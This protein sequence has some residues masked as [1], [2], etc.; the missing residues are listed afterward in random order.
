M[1]SLFLGFVLV[2]V[3]SALWAG[4]TIQHYRNIAQHTQISIPRCPEDE[5]LV[6]AGSFTNGRWTWYSCG[7]ARDDF[8]TT[9]VNTT[10]A[11]CD[12]LARWAQ[13]VESEQY[14]PRTERALAR[15]AYSSV[16]TP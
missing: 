8:N 6:G 4:Q 3:L 5:V 2:Y 16:C 10:L 1:S 11:P 9:S 13:Q 7:P 14:R 15:E 12:R